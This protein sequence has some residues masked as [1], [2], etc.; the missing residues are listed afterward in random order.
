M[1]SDSQSAANVPNEPNTVEVAVKGLILDPVTNTPIV[2][3]RDEDTERF[4]P[5]W[6]GEFEAQA[7]ALALEGIESPRPMTHDLMA[8]LLD[9]LDGHLDRIL[10]CDLQEGTFFAQLV[11]GQGNSQVV[12]DA[13]PSDA[14]ALGLRLEATILVAETVFDRVQD[15]DLTSRLSHEEKIRKWLEEIDPDELGQ[16]EM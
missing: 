15:A 9:T 5:I 8:A 13:R 3:L 2:I 11:L 14:I 7:I 1:H 6:I 10:I 12:L 4:L 16:Y